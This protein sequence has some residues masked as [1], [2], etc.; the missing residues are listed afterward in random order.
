MATDGKVVTNTG[1]DM[2]AFLL[3]TRIKSFHD[4]FEKKIKDFPL[5]GKEMLWNISSKYA[6][7]MLRAETFNQ[8]KLKTINKEFM[9]DINS[10]FEKLY[11]IRLD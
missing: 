3:L 6:L 10:N 1:N 2:D 5:D 11:G 8:D 4:Q 7:Y 9:D